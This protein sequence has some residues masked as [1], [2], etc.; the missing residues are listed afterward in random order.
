MKYENKTLKEYCEHGR[1]KIGGLV[2]SYMLGI[3]IE[4]KFIKISESVYDDS[5][6]AI[7]EPQRLLSYESPKKWKT[8]VNYG[9]MR[10]NYD[11]DT[12]FSLNV[13]WCLRAS[14]TSLNAHIE[15]SQRQVQQAEKILDNIS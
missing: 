12:R 3:V 11:L 4:Y 5:K 13:E 6:W 14:I 8:T 10:A 2:Y 7:L 1:L 15:S 9:S